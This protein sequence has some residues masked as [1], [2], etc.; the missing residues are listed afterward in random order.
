[1]IRVLA[2]DDHPL[3]R[4]G[5][6][7]LIG[8]QT[9]MELVAEASNGREALEQFRTHRPDVTLMD[10]QMPEMSGL[11][12]MSAIRA[13]YPEARIIMLTTYAGDAQVSR[14]LRGGASG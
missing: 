4:E 5:I 11:D 2:V 7:A 10:L 6:S 8:N 3:L 12:A 1:M 13:E 9:D 14:A